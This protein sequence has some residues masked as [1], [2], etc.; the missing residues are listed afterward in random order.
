MEL[1]DYIHEFKQIIDLIYGTY[2]DSMD[3][4]QLNIIHI[5]KFKDEFKKFH[6]EYRKSNPDKNI[7]DPS[8]MVR[9]YV[10]HEGFKYAH[11]SASEVDIISRNSPNGT[12]SLLIANLCLVAIYQ[13]WEDHYRQMIA[14]SL[15]VSKNDIQVA[16]FGDIKLLRE[17]II[18]HRGISTPKVDRCK[19]VK[20][21]KQGEQI[22]I[23]KVMFEQLIE[24]VL[25]C[26]HKMEI[27]PNQF[28]VSS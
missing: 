26:L 13:Y 6:D 4:Y 2:L 9:V 10:P 25:D 19:I 11:H 5:N 3:G 17:S 12:N 24:E 16:V 14:R 1:K 15:N 28:I 27:N 21:F 22:Q 23:R 20:W 8:N 7:S 18:H